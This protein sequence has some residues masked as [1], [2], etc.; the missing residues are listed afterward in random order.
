MESLPVWE[1][2]E[3]LAN[4]LSHAVMVPITIYLTTYL[5]KQQMKVHDRVNIFG[6]TVYGL[7]V[8]FLFLN[9]SLY[10]GCTYEPVKRVLRYIDHCTIFFQIA[11]SYTPCVLYAMRTYTGIALLIYIWVFAVIGIISKIFFFDKI[12]GTYIYLAMGWSIIVCIKEF[13]RSFDFSQKLWIALGGVSYSIGCI[14]F[15]IDKPFFH[16]IFHF[17]ISG[18]ALCQFYAIYLLGERFLNNYNK[19]DSKK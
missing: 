16:L 14:F 18:G 12:E 19:K 17:F 5:I 6:V 13:N 4:C 1:P 3:E 2:G 8:L 11:G 10:H 7:C 9:S 15:E